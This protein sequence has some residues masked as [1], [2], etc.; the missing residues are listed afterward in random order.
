MSPLRIIGDEFAVGRALTE[1]G[2]HL[3]A[4]ADADLDRPP[5]RLAARRPW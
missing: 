4:Q 1:L 2:L 3:I 5:A